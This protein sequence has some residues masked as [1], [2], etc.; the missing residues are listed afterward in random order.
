MSYIVSSTEP[1]GPSFPVHD[2]WERARERWGD[3]VKSVHRSEDGNV[4][5]IDFEPEG[6]PGYSI[7]VQSSGEALSTDGAPQQAAA[8]AVWARS[9]LPD[10]VPAEVWFYDDH[11]HVV[12]TPSLRADE[13]W[14]HYV[15]GFSAADPGGAGLPS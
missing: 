10:A 11:G 14:Q 1:D 3:V 9:L 7:R 8:V 12:L 6:E 5:T 15:E 2:I 4:L 13:F